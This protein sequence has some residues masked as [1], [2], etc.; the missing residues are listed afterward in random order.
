MTMIQ[1]AKLGALVFVLTLSACTAIPNRDLRTQYL[2]MTRQLGLTPVYPPREEFNVGDVYFVSG[3]DSKPDDTSQTVRIWLGTID[4]VRHQANRYMRSRINLEDTVAASNVLTTGGQ[5]KDFEAGTVTLNEDARKTLPLVTFPTVTGAASSAGALGSFGFT[6]AFGFNFGS[7]E[8]V[9]ID[10]TDTRAFG[11]P[12]GATKMTTTLRDEYLSK[13]C[14]RK[15]IFVPTAQNLGAQKQIDIS[16]MCSK[17]RSCGFAV[18]TRTYTTRQIQYRYTSARIA[19]L[20][21]ARSSGP[22]GAD[23]TT[24]QLPTSVDINLTVT[25]KNSA[26]ELAKIANA[27]Q[28]SVSNPNNKAEFDGLNFV[29]FQGNAL[30]FSRVFQKPVAVAFDAS[31]F[32]VGADTPFNCG[33]QAADLENPMSNTTKPKQ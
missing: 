16:T 15:N 2:E 23:A 3:N 21:A 27:L 26:E 20:A 28:S 32:G 13:I 11:A 29:G 1:T 8:T 25:G 12:I 33:V 6:N 22:S 30:A 31:V 17:G 24:P 18:I 10:F 19:R 5:Q 9:S 7:S 14:S 4:D